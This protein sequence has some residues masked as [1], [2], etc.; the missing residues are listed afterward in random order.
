MDLLR[1][2]LSRIRIVTK[3]TRSLEVI[4]QWTNVKIARN[5]S[6]RLKRVID[7]SS[8]SL[9]QSFKVKRVYGELKIIKAFVD[10]GYD[11]THKKFLFKIEKSDSSSSYLDQSFKE[12]RIYGELKIIKAFVDYGYDHTPKILL[13]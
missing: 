10:Y 2:N 7:S 12:K 9:D 11:H 1:L 3:N 6:S 13:L 8:S 4:P 5:F